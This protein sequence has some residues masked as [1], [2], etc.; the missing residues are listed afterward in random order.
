MVDELRILR[1]KAVKRPLMDSMTVDV[2][3]H[4]IHPLEH[5]QHTST[6]TVSNSNLVF[7]VDRLAFLHSLIQNSVKH[8]ECRVVSDLAVLRVLAHQLAYGGSTRL[9]RR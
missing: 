5:C 7:L 8:P 1:R 9:V 2:S 4:Q 6:L 3:L